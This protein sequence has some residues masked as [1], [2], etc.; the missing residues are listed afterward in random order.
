MEKQKNRVEIREKN[1]RLHHVLPADLLQAALA[2]LEQNPRLS[3]HVYRNNI[4]S[5]KYEYFAI[6]EKVFVITD[7]LAI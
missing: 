6:S 7:I 4:L 3:I 2:K 5:Q 1:G